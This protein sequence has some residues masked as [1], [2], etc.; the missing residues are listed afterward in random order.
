MRTR[1]LLLLAVG[2]GLAILAAGVAFLLMLAG[3]D[4][5]PAPVPVGEVA[6]VG[7]VAV[8]VTGYDE[9]GGRATVALR[10]GGVDDPD[11]TDGFRLFAGTPRAPT[12]RGDADCTAVTV[13]DRECTLTFDLAGAPGGS[14]VLRYQRGDDVV[15][16][17]LALP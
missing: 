11:G 10:I 1:T 13:A 7:D 14:R 3:G 16:W 4:E 9:A 17:V 12:G 15:H 6:H 8:T 5:A 2:C